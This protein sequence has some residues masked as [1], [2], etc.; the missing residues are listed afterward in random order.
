MYEVRDGLFNRVVTQHEDTQ[1]R[2]AAAF[3]V[4][5]TKA[6]EAAIDDYEARILGALE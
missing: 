5:E 6:I 2:L 3:K 4:S 1:Y